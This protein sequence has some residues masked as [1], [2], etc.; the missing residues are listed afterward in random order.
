MNHVATG[1]DIG[2]VHLK[3]AHLLRSG[4]HIRLLF[5]EQPFEIW[6]EPQRLAPT[7]RRLGAHAGDAGAH[8]VTLTAELSD[9]F[10]GRAAGVRAVLAAVTEALDTTPFRVLDTQ[11][12]LLP[13]AA[14]RRAPLRV[15]SANWM[16]TALLAARHVR[17]GLLVDIGSTTT[18]IV[19]FAGGRPRPEGTED[20]R[21][22][23]SGELVYSGVLRTPPAALAATVPLPG[24]P[25][26]TIPEHF[27]QMGDVYVILG[28]LTPREYTAATP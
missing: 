8:A 21:R 25:C 10:P 11:G 5:R 9:V 4:R 18:D 24:G 26:R 16:A 20:R 19:P 28:R 13:A 1:W 17:R 2:G 7:L 23:M 6:R 15:A 3:A 14:A 22:L 12:A 27:T